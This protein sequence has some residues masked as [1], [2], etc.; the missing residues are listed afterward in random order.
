M[1]KVY[2]SFP[3]IICSCLIGNYFSMRLIRRREILSE[4]I[5]LLECSDTRLRYT[6][7]PLV[8]IYAENF[9][10]FSFSHDEPFALQWRRM[11]D[12]FR[13]VLKKGDLSL[14]YRYGDESGASDAD[15]QHRLIEMHIGL[16]RAQL[17]DAT[18]DIERRSRLYRVLGFSVGMCLVL[19]LI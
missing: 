12:T 14:L 1:L 8:E 4:Y 13:P 10:S 16:L 18:A 11:A 5:A 15:T 17:E 3:I 19:M 9:A 2:L 7:S 6:S